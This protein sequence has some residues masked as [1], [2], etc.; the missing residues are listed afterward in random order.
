MEAGFSPRSAGLAVARNRILIDCRFCDKAKQ[1]LLDQV[2]KPLK[3]GEPHPYRHQGKLD[4]KRVWHL[5]IDGHAER[6]ICV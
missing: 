1:D 2:R 6:F 3:M 5:S 4:K